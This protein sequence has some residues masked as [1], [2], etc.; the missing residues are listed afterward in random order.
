MAQ[1]HKSLGAVC[2]ACVTARLRRSGSTQGSGSLSKEGK[3]WKERGKGRGGEG[4]TSRGR[5]GA[6]LLRVKAPSPE[7]FLDFLYQNGDFCAFWVALFTVY[8]KLFY[9]QNGAFG[10]PKLKVT[11]AFAL[12]KTERE[13]EKGKAKQK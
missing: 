12:A 1:W 3:G 5:E 10:L 8:L 2:L 6:L 7:N 4:P 9:M 13:T 11:A